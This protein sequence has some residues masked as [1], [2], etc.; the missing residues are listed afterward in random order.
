[1]GP[2]DGWSTKGSSDTGVPRRKYWRFPNAKEVERQRA[3]A[4]AARAAGAAAA[5]TALVRKVSA[6]L[7]PFNNP[8]DT[9]D[10]MH[11]E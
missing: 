10:F 5:S 11:D 9:E 7:V 2:P 1:M 8:A 3:A 6:A 4:E